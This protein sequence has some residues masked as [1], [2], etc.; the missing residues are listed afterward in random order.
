MTQPNNTPPRIT[1]EQQRILNQVDATFR[2]QGGEESDAIRLWIKWQNEQMLQHITLDD[3]S[4]SE[5][6]CL[7]AIIGP[8][9]S[10]VLARD[11]G[12]EEFRHGG[13]FLGGNGL[14]LV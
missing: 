10:R 12:L 5:L 4:T 8:L 14:R 3:F 13:G 9:F 6:L 1:E 11:A 7:V 2:F